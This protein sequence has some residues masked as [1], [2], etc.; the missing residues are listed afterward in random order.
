MYINVNE[1]VYFL[2]K[3]LITQFVIL[4]AGVNERYMTC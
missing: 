4:S 3:W 2:V 1:L